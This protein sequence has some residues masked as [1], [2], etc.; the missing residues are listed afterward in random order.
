[1][2]VGACPD[3]S[4]RETTKHAESDGG[5]P[6]IAI[7]VTP[8]AAFP[9]HADGNLTPTLN[10]SC[11]RCASAD[12][13]D[14]DMHALPDPALGHAPRRSSYSESVSCRCTSVASCGACPP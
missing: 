14:S 8:A 3:P 2:R 5:H 1:M 4:R 6:G 13:E 12:T 10:I 9:P 11:A 7:G